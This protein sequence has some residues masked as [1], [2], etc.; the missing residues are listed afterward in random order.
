MSNPA[1]AKNAEKRTEQPAEAAPASAATRTAEEIA[2]A[3]ASNPVK[4]LNQNDLKEGDFS[5]FAYDATVPS[6]TPTEHLLDPS[7]WQNVAHKFKPRAEV[8]VCPEDGSW[9]ARLFVRACGRSWARME[10]L[11][12]KVFETNAAVPVSAS[13][14]KV[15]HMPM[16]PGAPWRVVNVVTLQSVKDDLPTEADARRF[17]ANL[18]NAMNK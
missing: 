9:Y 2:K 5:H 3:T 6:N 1:A 16:R 7:F 4:P 15:E 12:A 13:Q 10:I 18:T 11:F 14:Y 17:I 8:S